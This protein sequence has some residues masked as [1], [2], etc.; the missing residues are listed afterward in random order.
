VTM[1]SAMGRRPL[2]LAGH[3]AKQLLAR[4]R[5]PPG[6]T[7]RLRF[8]DGEHGQDLIRGGCAAQVLQACGHTLRRIHALDVT[9]VF[10]HEP[11]PPGTV[12]VH[13]D[14]GPNNILLDPDTLTVTAIL[15]WEWAHPGEALEDLAWCEWIVRSYHSEHVSALEKFFTA[16]G[17]QPA[18]PL[19][20][21]QMVA[22]ARSLAEFTQR[23][24]HA[25]Q[26]R[27]QT[28]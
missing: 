17:S 24:G 11:A 15:D 27:V 9:T 22:Q 13:G 19:R 28:R 16:Y 2:V 10:P 8:L 23:W 3:D 7:L 21:Q 14:Y 6:Y 20:H 18:W 25:D 12:L 26:G 5:L 4:H 1:S